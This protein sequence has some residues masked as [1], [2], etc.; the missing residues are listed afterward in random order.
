M[1]HN[2]SEAYVRITM[3]QIKRM[4]QFY[5]QTITLV[6]CLLKNRQSADAASQFFLK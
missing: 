3:G 4:H 2:I 1:S 6:H 5:V